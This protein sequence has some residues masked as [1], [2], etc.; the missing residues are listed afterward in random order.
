VCKTT[1]FFIWCAKSAEAIVVGVDL[2]EELMLVKVL[3]WWCVKPAGA[4]PLSTRYAAL[5]R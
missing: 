1:P 3:V 2:D 4:I 5:A